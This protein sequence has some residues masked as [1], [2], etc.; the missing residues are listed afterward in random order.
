VS[1]R[2]LPHCICS[3]GQTG[4]DRGALDWAIQYGI[5][6]GGYCPKGRL[7]EDGIIPPQ[8]QLI[9]T[10]SSRY[11]GRTEANVKASD[12]TLIFVERR[13]GRGSRLTQ[14]LCIKHNKP[15]LVVSDSTPIQV[16]RDFLNQHKP[17]VLNVAGSRASAAP[18]IHARVQQVLSA[19]FETQQETVGQS[20]QKEQTT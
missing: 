13:L 8:Y 9:E 18:T 10:R 1:T 3:G 12:A 14:R 20:P 5:K 2:H 16:V 15:H 6:H 17:R 11:P 7:A 19:V 4:A